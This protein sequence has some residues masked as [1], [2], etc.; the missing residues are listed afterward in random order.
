M[1]RTGASSSSLRPSKKR[2]SRRGRPLR[3]S[4]VINRK[5]ASAKEKTTST[6]SKPNLKDYQRVGIVEQISKELENGALLKVAIQEAAG[7]FGVSVDTIKRL[8]KLAEETSAAH[9]QGLYDVSSRIK[10]KSGM[11]YKLC[12]GDFLESFTNLPIEQRRTRCAI[13][14]V[15]GKPE[16][17]VSYMMKRLDI[18]LYNDGNMKYY[19]TPSERQALGLALPSRASSDPEAQL[20]AATNNDD[21]ALAVDRAPDANERDDVDDDGLEQHKPSNHSM[22]VD[23][24]AVEVQEQPNEN[25]AT[26]IDNGPMNEPP[27][28]PIGFVDNNVPA[29]EPMQANEI[30]EILDDDSVDENPNLSY[31]PGYID[32]NGLMWV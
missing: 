6:K 12:Y 21:T 25:D 8:W 13:A 20:E 15:L 18:Q 9:P 23:D 22:A 16:A 10:A 5:T 26:D 19:V 7:D 14:E 30:I 28:E 17:T 2:P 32:E 3:S 31:E 29:N 11:R 24:N 27:N 4:T 1:T